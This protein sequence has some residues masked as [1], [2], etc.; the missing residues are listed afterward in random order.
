VTPA[1][2]LP[3]VGSL[4]L[5]SGYV[6]VRDASGAVIDRVDVELM[7]EP[8]PTRW[9]DDLIRER[10]GWLATRGAGVLRGF[11]V[12]YAVHAPVATSIESALRSACEGG[13]V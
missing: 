7:Y 6:L 11:C 5:H 3:R 9:C 8:R 10:F 12:T 4:E 2:H 13:V 1:T